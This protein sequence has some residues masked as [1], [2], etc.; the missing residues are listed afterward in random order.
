MTWTN[1][2]LVAD[3][4]VSEYLADGWVLTPAGDTFPVTILAQVGDAEPIVVGVA[5]L[6]VNDGGEVLTQDRMRSALIDQVDAA[7]R[8]HLSIQLGSIRPIVE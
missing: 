3:E 7:G 6:A 4:H 5:H 2:V 8:G 1:T